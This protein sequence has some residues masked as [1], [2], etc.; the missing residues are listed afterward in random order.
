M[1]G[2]FVAWEVGGDRSVKVSNKSMVVEMLP[3][4]GGR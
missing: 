2:C 3:I 4:K 1:D